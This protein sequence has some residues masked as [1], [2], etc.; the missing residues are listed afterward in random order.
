MKIWKK[1]FSIGNTI[2]MLG[3]AASALFIAFL[4]V[5]ALIIA[6]SVELWGMAPKAVGVLLLLSAV[7]WACWRWLAVPVVEDEGSPAA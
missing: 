6:P 5:A 4:W 7:L 2:L 1:K 3:L